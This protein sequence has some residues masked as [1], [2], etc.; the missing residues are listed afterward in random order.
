MFTAGHFPGYNINP[1]SYDIL[2]SIPS[3]SCLAMD[4]ERSDG[5]VSFR[6]HYLNGI[7]FS[8]TDTV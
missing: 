4:L 3:F 7:E 8:G 5:D 6:G 2:K 1:D